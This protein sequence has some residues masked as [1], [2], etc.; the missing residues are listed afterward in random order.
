MDSLH[1]FDTSSEFGAA[2][3]TSKSR[4]RRRNL[5]KRL[6]KF[7]SQGEKHRHLF[8]MIQMV[9]EFD[10]QVQALQLL[11]DDVDEMLDLLPHYS[12]GH[13]LARTF[14][15]D[16]ALAW[17]IVALARTDSKSLE[18]TDTR[19]WNG[20]QL[21]LA[22]QMITITR[23]YDKRQHSEDRRSMDSGYGMSLEDRIEWGKEVR[24]E[25]SE[26]TIPVLLQNAT[27]TAERLA[28]LLRLLVEWVEIDEWWGQDDD[29]LVKD[30]LYD[31]VLLGGGGY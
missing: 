28:G 15:K 13:Q 2:S 17:V 31:F 10:D 5:N 3:T 4:R 14:A 16:R 9:D 29:R 12:P 8:D 21:E 25:V 1:H 26:K 27:M 23:N 11:C 7:Q 18:K 22:R 30:V 6:K 24:L 20:A 19:S